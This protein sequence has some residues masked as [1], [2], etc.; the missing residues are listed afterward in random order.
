MDYQKAILDKDATSKTIRSLIGK[1]ALTHERLA[2]LLQLNSPRVIYEW[3]SGKKM[4]YVENMFNLALIF[5]M[6][7]EDLLIMK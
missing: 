7:M 2:E 4:P 6:K 1:S 3:Q 5:N